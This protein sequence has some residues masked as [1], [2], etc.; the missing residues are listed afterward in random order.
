M[1][2]ALA[3]AAAFFLS[4]STAAFARGGMEHIM[5]TVKSA[6]ASSITVATKGKAVEV[7][8]DQATRYDGVATA[9]DLMPG[10]RVVVHAKRVGPGLHAEV[11]KFRKHK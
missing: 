5:G 3:A 6:S 1:K 2:R 11:V 4:T 8:L 10:D 7:Q 9:A